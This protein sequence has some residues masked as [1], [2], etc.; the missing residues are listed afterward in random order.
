L[1][2]DQITTQQE[3]NSY[4]MGIFEVLMR[5]RVVKTLKLFQPCWMLLTRLASSAK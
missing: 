5:V 1:A 2:I 4:E 3:F